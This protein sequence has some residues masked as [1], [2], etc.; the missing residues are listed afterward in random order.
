[1]LYT[2]S[3][4]KLT[5]SVLWHEGGAH[6]IFTNSATL[7]DLRTASSELKKTAKGKQFRFLIHD[8]S[9]SRRIANGLAHVL[10]RSNEPGCVA[11]GLSFA[12][13]AVVVDDEVLRRLIEEASRHVCVPTSAFATLSQAESWI[14]L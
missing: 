7:V 4:H 5:V 8:F 9:R 2:L 3:E 1:M 14:G 11:F 6:C 10:M 12:K 13:I